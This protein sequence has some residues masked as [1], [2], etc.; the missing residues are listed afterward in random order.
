MQIRF[1]WSV[2]NK[3]SGTQNIIDN[4]NQNQIDVNY[5]IND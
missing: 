4:L 2:Q 3:V 1:I 5:D